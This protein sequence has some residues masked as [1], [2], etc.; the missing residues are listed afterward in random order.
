MIK[1]KGFFIN[2]YIYISNDITK[3]LCYHINLIHNVLTV[4]LWVLGWVSGCVA[5]FT[6]SSPIVTFI[7]DK[8]SL[9]P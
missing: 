1:I 9:L 8:Q 7:I 2:N 6:V 5:G 4:P 3:F